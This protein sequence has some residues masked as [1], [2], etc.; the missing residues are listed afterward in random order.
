MKSRPSLR[1]NHNHNRNRNRTR[2]AL[3]MLVLHLLLLLLLLSISALPSF[4]ESNSERDA[5]QPSIVL[6][7]NNTINTNNLSVD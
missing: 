7:N 2:R 1:G 3:H 5:E 6:Q 4:V